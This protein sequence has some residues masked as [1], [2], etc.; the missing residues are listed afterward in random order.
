MY[1]RTFAPPLGEAGYTRVLSPSRHPY[2]TAD[3]WVCVLIYN[4]RHWQSFFTLVG[5]EDLAADPRYATMRGRNEHIDA[6]YGTVA[7]TLRS[8]TTVEWILALQSV[9]IPVGRMNTLDSLMDDPHLAAVGFFQAVEHPS[10]GTIN[11]IRTPITW[12]KS[13]PGPQRPVPNLG[14]HSS[15]VLLENGFGVG[16]IASLMA[17]GVLGAGLRDSG[18]S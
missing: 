7:E 10:E 2:Q 5:R 13:S 11:S 3:G 4:D 1:G 12:S 18:K 17:A 14:E 8:R 16:E 9:D 6:L 15:E